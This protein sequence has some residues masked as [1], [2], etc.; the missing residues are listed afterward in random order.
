MKHAAPSDEK[1]PV[2]EQSASHANLEH[3][4][5]NRQPRSVKVRW[6]VSCTAGK[7]R[8]GKRLLLAWLMGHNRTVGGVSHTERC[9]TKMSDQKL[10]VGAC[11]AGSC[12]SS[13]FQAV[14]P[15]NQR[16][17][18]ALRYSS[19]CCTRHIN[20]SECRRLNQVNTINQADK[21]QP[22]DIC[23]CA[24]QHHRLS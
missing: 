6:T 18:R 10:L 9:P 4:H 15:T 16:E 24:H 22:P 12:M 21:G 2:K 7:S 13:S 8:I 23:F 19:L 17:N 1:R 20:M 3:W 14:R 5:Y 11:T